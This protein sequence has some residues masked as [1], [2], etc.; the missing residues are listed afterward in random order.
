MA[1]DRNGRKLHLGDI[2][3]LTKGM[4][5]GRQSKAI[6]TGLNGEDIYLTMYGP[7]YTGEVHRYGCEMTIT[8]SIWHDGL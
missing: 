1:N 7:G 3:R 4:R 6:V 8:E 2:V 5:V